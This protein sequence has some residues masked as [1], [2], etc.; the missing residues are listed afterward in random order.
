M[1]RLAQEIHR[2]SLWQVLVSY[3]AVSWVTLE[4]TG[5]L[6]EHLGLPG[7]VFPS[8]LTILLVGLPAV[9]ATAFYHKRSQNQQQSE[10]SGEK[11][12]LKPERATASDPHRVFRWRNVLVAGVGAFL[13]LFGLAG[14]YVVIQDRGR[15]FVPADTAAAAADPGVA[16]LPFSVSGPAL[17]NVDLRESLVTLLP[18]A[19]DGIEGIRPISSMTLWARWREEVPEGEE[20]DLETALRV[21]EET[22]ARYAVVGTGVGLGADVRLAA[23]IYELPDGVLLDQINVE[24]PP[25][26]LLRLVDRFAVEAVRS[27]GGVTEGELAR[28][29]LTPVMTESPAALKEFLRGEAAYRRADWSTALSHLERALAAD[30][31]FGA[32]HYRKALTL[33]WGPWFPDIVE[34]MDQHWEAALKYTSSERMAMAIRGQMLTSLLPGQSYTIEDLERAQRDLVSAVR[35]YP[36]DAELWTALA[37]LYFHNHMMGVFDDPLAKSEAALEQTMELNPDAAVDRVHL[38]QL[39][40]WRADS[41][42]ARERIEEFSRLAPGG[43][44]DRTNQILWRMIFQDPHTP[45]ELEAA[46]DTLEEL[47]QLGYMDLYVVHHSAWPIAEAVIRRKHEAN[48]GW[49]DCSRFQRSLGAGRWRYFMEEAGHIQVPFW[50]AYCLSEAYMQ[51]IEVAGFDSAAAAAA[52]TNPF[53]AAWLAADDGAWASFEAALG[54]ARDSAAASLAAGDA[55]SAD[56]WER[57]TNVLEAYG[58][59]KQGDPDPLIQA[60]ESLPLSDRSDGQGWEGARWWLGMLYLENDRPADAIRM[61]ETFWGWRRWPI[62]KY[63]IGRA[64]EQLGDMEKARESYAALVEAWEDADPELQPW[65]ERG[66]QALVRLGPLDQ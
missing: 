37:E 30:S 41:A 7:W 12:H 6:V 58:E 13:V 2:R 10:G 15:S 33:G 53:F 52:A 1:K 34:V 45:E 14:L 61:F 19:L 24:G 51:G 5:T 64:Y 22:G 62:A 56:Q 18:L 3:A 40:L 43:D 20:A 4:V 59:W 26:S 44:E 49:Y 32:A 35:R 25:D 23:D 66:R 9:L 46:V 11:G 48:P 39:A 27:I 50:K 8:A 60:L 28:I 63:Y 54:S 65:V 29:D 16:F 31:T 17:A 38:V 36:D 21:A 55:A 47:G 57:W 42:L